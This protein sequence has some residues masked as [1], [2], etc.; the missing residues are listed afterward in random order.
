MKELNK[1]LGSIEPSFFWLTP[2]SL[3][4]CLTYL[5]LSIIVFFLI[6]ISAGFWSPTQFNSTPLASVTVPILRFIELGTRP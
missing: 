3:L 6:Q 5:N 1:E 4:F 2:M